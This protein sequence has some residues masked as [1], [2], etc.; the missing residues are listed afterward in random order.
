MSIYDR[1][2]YWE[3][4]D[5]KSGVRPSRWP[6]PIRRSPLDRLL[7]GRRR[8]RWP[9]LLAALV[10]ILTGVTLAAPAVLA[11]RC[12]RGSWWSNTVTCWRSSWE[13]LSER[14]AVADDTAAG[15]CGYYANASGHVVPRP[16]GDW[17]GQGTPS[18]ATARCRDGTYSFSEHPQARGTCNYHGGVLDY[19][20]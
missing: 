11:S 4:R 17:H 15:A 13:A 6:N 12:D 7:R 9:W 14:V 3:E 10:T 16:C 19:L 8:R 5:K 18:S 20:R 1:D 2:Y